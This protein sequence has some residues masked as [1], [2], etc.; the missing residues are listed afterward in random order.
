MGD[1]VA[2]ELKTGQPVPGFEIEFTWALGPW[3]AIF[4]KQI[5]LIQE[6]LRRAQ[7]DDRVIVYLS[8]PISSRGGSQ[9]LTNVDIANFTARRLLN[10]WGERLFILNPAAYQLESK[11]GTGLII[12]HLKELYPDKNPNDYLQTLHKEYQPGG[13]DYMRMWTRVLV[14]DEYL[15]DGNLAGKNCGGLFDAFYFLGPSDVRTF[16]AQSGG[17]SLTAAIEE[18]FARKYSID[19]DFRSAFE[20]TGPA[21]QTKI[22]NLSVQSDRDQWLLLRKRFFRYYAARA[23]TTFSAGSHDEWNIFVR[24]N[25]VRLASPLYGPGEQLAGF[26]D[27]RQIDTGASEVEVSRGYAVV[28]QVKALPHAGEISWPIGAKPSQ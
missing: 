27:G 21:G 2:T 19:P 24:L 6:D 10:D 14:G 15:R 25:K 8:C 23:S 4:D 20:T 28:P 22:L 7:A 11:E 26:F 1:N 12:R 5:E 18:Y 9:S 16:F 13:G 3:L 17:L